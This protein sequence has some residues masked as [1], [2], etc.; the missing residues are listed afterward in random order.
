MKVKSGYPVSSKTNDTVLFKT[1]ASVVYDKNG[2]TVADRLDNI[3]VY[4]HA[5]SNG[6]VGSNNDF[7]DDLINAIVL[8]DIDETDVVMPTSEINDNVVSGS[9]TWSSKK[10]SDKINTVNNRLD[11]LLVSKTL[12]SGDESELHDI[13]VGYDGVTYQSAGTAVRNQFNELNDLVGEISH[14]YTLILQ[15][16]SYTSDSYINYYSGEMGAKGED[17]EKLFSA[18]DFVD[19]GEANYI[20]LK[21][22]AADN[23]QNQNDYRGIAFYDVNKAFITGTGIKYANGQ[24]V[25]KMVRPN[26][27]KYIRYTKN[28]LIDTTVENI[29]VLQFYNIVDST[30][31]KNYVHNEVDASLNKTVTYI[32]KDALIENTYI[33]Y[34]NGTEIE[35]E[36]EGVCAT[37]FIELESNHR[38]I[39]IPELSGTGGGGTDYRGLAFYDANKAYVSGYKYEL[40]IPDYLEIPENAKYV[41]FTTFIFEDHHV[42]VFSPIPKVVQELGDSETDV[43]SQKTLTREINNIHELLQDVILTDTNGNKYKLI[44]RLDGTLATEKLS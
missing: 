10:T 27:A 43:V 6:F 16:D 35:Y 21:I 23:G 13:R 31:M 38:Y 12:P 22:K 40:V 8:E 20:V 37:D 1:S 25:Y 28:G 41:R 14:K 32:S 11:N 15:D 9:M 3:D 39:R 36:F 24:E 42:E 7:N 18:S 30:F 29:P 5:K 17:T 33:Y 26:N 4:K 2:S 44:V 34:G 19:I